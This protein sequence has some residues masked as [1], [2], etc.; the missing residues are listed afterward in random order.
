MLSHLKVP[1]GAQ[2]ACQILNAVILCA[3]PEQF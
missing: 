2:H 1:K 3:S